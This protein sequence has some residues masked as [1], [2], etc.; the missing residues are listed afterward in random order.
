MMAFAS[1]Q[2]FG[3]IAV[4]IVVSYESNKFS[5]RRVDNKFIR[6]LLISFGILNIVAETVMILGLKSM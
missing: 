1:N 3:R 6:I 5:R 4:A 2:H